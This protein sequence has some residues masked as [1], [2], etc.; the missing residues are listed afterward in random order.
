MNILIDV[1]SNR[2]QRVGLNVQVS[3]WASANAG[4]PQ[5]SILGPLLFLIYI[6]D[7]SDN[8]SS[9]VKLFAD[10]TSLFSVTHDVNVSARELNDDLR[11]ISNWAFQWKM[12]FNPDVNKQAQEIIFSRK[13]KSNIHPLPVFNNNIV[14]QANSQKRNYLR[15]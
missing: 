12:S 5:G 4:V 11:K 7:L 13:I 15:L 2:K 1:L 8:L 14:S 10:N 9:N 3:A 6:S